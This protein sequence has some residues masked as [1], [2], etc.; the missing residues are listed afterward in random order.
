MR[1]RQQTLLLALV[2]GI[3]VLVAERAIAQDAGFRFGLGMPLSSG[4]TQTSQTR[5][6]ARANGANAVGSAGGEISTTTPAAPASPQD[7]ASS[8]AASPLGQSIAGPAPG[9]K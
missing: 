5:F 8:L 3:A 6:F 2:I 1:N 9:R 7:R 4:Q